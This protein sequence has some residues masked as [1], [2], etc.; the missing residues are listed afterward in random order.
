M[1]FHNEM[2]N[3]DFRFDVMDETRWP[4]RLGFRVS[5]D[6][7]EQI[8]EKRGAALDWNRA[9]R[10]GLTTVEIPLSR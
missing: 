4:I 3:S 5:L 7:A 2:K 8:A 6:E 9:H 10:I 1:K